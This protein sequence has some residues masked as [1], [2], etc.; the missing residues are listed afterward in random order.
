MYSFNYGTTSWNIYD[1]FLDPMTCFR[2]V[3]TITIALEAI[4][5]HQIVTSSY[6]PLPMA[7]FVLIDLD[8]L[9]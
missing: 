8:G 6:N 4:V 5:L 7:S 3:D 2:A 1:G 9:R